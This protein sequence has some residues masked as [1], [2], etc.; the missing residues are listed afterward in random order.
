LTASNLIW[1]AAN[2]IYWERIEGRAILKDRTFPCP[3]CGTLVRIDFGE[4]TTAGHRMMG[5]ADVATCPNAECDY[6]GTDQVDINDR[7]EAYLQSQV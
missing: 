2:R 1:R 6:R 4:D 7:I 3:K 5:K